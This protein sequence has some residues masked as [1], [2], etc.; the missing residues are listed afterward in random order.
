M[1]VNAPR[2]ALAPG[3]KHGTG[4]DDMPVRTLVQMD[5]PDHTVYRKISVEWFKKA[6]VARLS[7][8]AAELAKRSVDH[9]ADLGGECD[10]LTDIAMHYPLYIIL[11]LL[12][13]PEEDFPRM[14]KLTQEMFGK[15]DPD[16][17][18]ET[19][20]DALIANLLE[21]VEY[22]QGLIEDRRAKPR[23][24][25]ASVIANAEVDGE[26]IGVLEA[27]GYY[28]IIATAGH[29]TTSSAIS[30]GFAALLAHP[31][32]LRLL[33]D[34]PALV[35][36][37]VEEMFRY[38]SP[39]KQFMRTATSEQV[40]G[41]VTI[42][43]GGAVLLSFPAANRDERSVRATGHVRRGSRPEPAH[44]VRVR[45]PLLP[46]DPPRPPRDASV[47]QRADPTARSRRAGRR[48]RV[49]ADDLRRRPQTR[50]GALPPP[51]TPP[52]RGR[53]RDVYPRSEEEERCDVEA[54][55]LGAVRRVRD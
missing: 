25:L 52:R 16:M 17:A 24:D 26:P 19:E 29:D 6:N 46:R 36:T 41:G 37:A 45:R 2:P 11:A 3:A 55:R 32:Q 49:H 40:L 38:V 5:A 14:L 51:L 53:Q 1:W 4:R 43:E 7:D 20:G 50:P 35:P 12:G 44:R 21:F 10:F 22:F 31:D 27:V 13:L 8:R 15:D 54:K 9:M 23:D 47:L 42:P 18:R 33:M 39:V 34:D 30:G 48:T 28:V